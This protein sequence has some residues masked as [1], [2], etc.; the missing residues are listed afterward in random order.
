MNEENPLITFIINSEYI[1]SIQ[2]N[3]IALLVVMGVMLIILAIVKKDFLKR[4]EEFEVDETELG[5]GNQKIKLSPNKVDTQIAYKIWVELNTRKIG[6]EVDLEKDLLI[7]IYRSWY[8]FFKITRE[9]IKEVPAEKLSRED[10]RTIVNISMMMLNLGVRP[11]LT[12]WHA[13]FSRWYEFELLIEKDHFISPQDIQKKYPLFNELSIDLITVN[14]RLIKYKE[15][16][17]NLV[18]GL[19]KKEK[20]K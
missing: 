5:I 4:W 3:M 12:Q 10:T 1:L 13:K 6:L 2:V 15:S 16:L 8:E 20:R 7:H 19:G 14:R 9:L 11:H 18:S 17:T